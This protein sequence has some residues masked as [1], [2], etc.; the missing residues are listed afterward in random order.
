MPEKAE[1]V[2][3]GHRKRLRQ[4]Y[5]TQGLEGFQPHEA[6]E[7]LLFYAI[8]R[9]DTNLLAH[10][11]INRFGSLEAVLSAAPQELAQVEG[12]GESAAVLV[13]LLKPV[14]ALASRS[15]EKKPPRL[16][17]LQSLM[18]YCRALPFPPGQETFYLI[19]M[20]AQWR[21]VHTE[22]LFSGTINMVGVHS[23]IIVETALRHHACYAAVTHNHPS[24]AAFARRYRD[25][26][27]NQGL[28]GGDRYSA[29]RSYHR[30]RR[31][32]GQPAKARAAAA[33]DGVHW[34]GLPRRR[35]K[36]RRA[37][38][39]EENLRHAETNAKKRICSRKGRQVRFCV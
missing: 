33:D 7:L 15:R 31:A 29:V 9:R 21:V 8:P 27:E 32:D 12:V 11:L 28:A 34:P 36:P 17:N 30:R 2:H 23:R 1:N 5:L 4:R 13:S 20:D 37:A 16:E 14:T 3:D 24:G 38:E 19:C 10:Q 35:G 6:L 18:D 25:D 26:G 22:A 39:T